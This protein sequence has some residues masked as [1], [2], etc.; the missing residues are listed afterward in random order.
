MHQGAHP[1]PLPPR[2]QTAGAVL[3]SGETGNSESAAPIP[4][5]RQSSP[6]QIP[7]LPPRSMSSGPQAGKSPPPIARKPPHLATASTAWSSREVSDRDADGWTPRQPIPPRRPSSSVQA[8]GPSF[9]GS[10]ARNRRTSPVEVLPRNGSFS[11]AA[12]YARSVTASPFLQNQQHVATWGISESPQTMSGRATPVRGVGL[13]G[14]GLADNNSVTTARSARPPLPSR[15]QS[16]SSLSGAQKAPPQL[17]ARKPPPMAAA[18]DL[19]DDDIGD[20]MGG[21]KAI[22]PT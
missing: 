12:T 19:L 20:E 16:S 14:L 10:S 6:R 8:Y 7:A 9:D 13:V 22:E 11:P 1:L 17:P 15:K 3:T 5:E 4:I 18:V 21:W 2:Q